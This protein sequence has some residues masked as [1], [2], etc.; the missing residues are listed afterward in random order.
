MFETVDVLAFTDGSGS[1]KSKFY[2]FEAL[3]DRVRFVVR[4]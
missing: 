3:S 4:Y 2:I 1:C